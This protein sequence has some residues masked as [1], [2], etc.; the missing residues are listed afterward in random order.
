MTSTTPFLRSTWML[1][2]WLLAATATAQANTLDF[3]NGP[4][5]P[6]ICT[7]T[8]GTGTGPIT[9]CTNGSFVSQS[10]GDVAGV[11]DVAYSTPRANSPTGLRWWESNFN[12]LFGVLYAGQGNDFG[13]QA[14][15]EIRAL[16]P[17]ASVF[18]SRF[19]LGAFNQ[20]TRNTTVSVGLI[21]DTTP[22]WSFTG[23]VGNGAVAA[24]TFGLGLFAA[25]GLWIDWADSA[26]NVGIDN[27]EF[28]VVS[29]P[30]PEP[31]SA[32]LL[33]GGMLGLM[34]RRRLLAQR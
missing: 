19:D 5:S 10:Y 18:L 28:N 34:V 25:G 11:V 32:M 21:G 17:G 7:G 8:D 15:I 13:S 16:A 26:F 1:S 2:A 4:T 14:H 9:P 27:V 22:L 33:I 6:A 29:A 3:G 23:G 30:V 31:A 20:T 24:T 12:S